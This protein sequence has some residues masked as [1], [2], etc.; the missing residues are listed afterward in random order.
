L[1]PL[2]FRE[3]G[4]FFGH[5]ASRTEQLSAITWCTRQTIRTFPSKHALLL[6]GGELVDG[7]GSMA[8][9]ARASSNSMM[10]S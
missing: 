7:F 8:R 5:V 1:L 10:I 3:R 2:L 6:C 9:H 4:E